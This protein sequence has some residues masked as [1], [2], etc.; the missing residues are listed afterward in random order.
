MKWKSLLA[1][2]AIFIYVASF[3]QGDRKLSKYL[4]INIS[5]KMDT[6]S[7]FSIDK[8]TP[9]RAGWG[10]IYS[11]FTKAFISA[12][13]PV[14]EKANA[15]SSHS[16]NIMIDYEYH[17]T[18]FSNLRGQ[19]VD[20]SNGSQIIGTIT[21]E[22]KFEVDDISSGIADNI[23]S[24]NPVIQKAEIKKDNLVKEETQNMKQG[25]SKEDRLRELKDLFE[26]QLITKEDYDK[27]KQKIL[28]EQ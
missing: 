12:G 7:A 16:Y 10:I 26:K 4:T 9:K 6:V 11:A 23:K 14:V 2:M 24:K 28:E 19:I 8:N 18:Q 3:A 1:V 17:G 20:V 27:A 13:L 21:Y 22:K 15:A 25:R 5:G